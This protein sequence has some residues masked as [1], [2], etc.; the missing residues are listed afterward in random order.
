ML[1]CC[2][3]ETTKSPCRH[4]HGKILKIL[5]CCHR[6]QCYNR[7]HLLNPINFKTLL[8]QQSHRL[9]DKGDCIVLTFCKVP[10]CHFCI[11]TYWSLIDTQRVCGH[12]GEKLPIMTPPETKTSHLCSF[13]FQHLQHLNREKNKEDWLENGPMCWALTVEASL[14]LSSQDVP[15]DDGL[16]VLL[17]VH[18]WTE[19]HHI[20]GNITPHGWAQ[21]KHNNWIGLARMCVCVCVRCWWCRLPLTWWEVDEGDTLMAKPLDLFEFLA[22]PQGNAPL[23]EG[24]QVGAFRRPPHIRLRPAL[25]EHKTVFTC[26]CVGFFI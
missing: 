17:S 5:Q 25:H 23:V 3:Q 4:I 2:H 20:P 16:W 11:L 13:Q 10:R 8:V 12:P 19:G 22:T 9:K 7:Q 18:Q 6:Q 15:D 21:N 1:G 26:T 24:S 14:F